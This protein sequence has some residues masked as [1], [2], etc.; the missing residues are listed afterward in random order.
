[1]VKVA[2]MK[3]P[4]TNCD[5][6]VHHVLKNVIGLDS[7]IVWYKEYVT[8]RYDAVVVPG[9]FSYGDWLR[10]GAIAA[11]NVVMERVAED[12]SRGVPVLGICNGFQILVEAGMLPGALILNSSGRF[13]CRW[14]R[15]VVENA[16][17]PWLSLAR[18]RIMLDMPIA[19]AEGRYYIDEET[20]RRIANVSSIIRYAQ[21][22]N[23][24]GSLYD[25]AG[26]ADEKG[27]VLGLMPHPERASEPELVPRGFSPGGRIIFDSLAYSLKKGW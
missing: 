9:G 16:R 26:I 25:I 21:G 3:F 14:I 12:V 6:D 10:A 19:H 15:L 7:E 20:Y 13:V 23:P 1:M 4:G 11:R 5:E 24:N 27:L 2:I 18:D 22:W 17:G 8:N